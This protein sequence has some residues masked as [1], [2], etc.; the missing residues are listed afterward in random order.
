MAN[1]LPEK[2]LEYLKTFNKNPGEYTKEEQAEIGIF[3]QGLHRWEKNWND[4]AALLGIKDKT[5]EQFRKWVLDR[6]Y[7]RNLVP[8]NPK[9]LDDKTVDDVIEEDVAGSL[10]EQRQVL[11]KE[12]MK[13]RDERTNLNRTL[14]DEARLERFMDTLKDIAAQD[15]LNLPQLVNTTFDTEVPSCEAVYGLA[16]L[17]LGPIVD[18]CINTYNY[19]EAINR[20]NKIAEDIL[21]YCQLHNVHTLHFINMGDLIAGLIHPTIRLE[22]EYDVIE[23]VKIAAKLVAELVNC[24]R[25]AAPVVTYRSVVDNHARLMPDKHQHIEL[26][27][28]NR[29]IDTLVE[30]Y[31]SN[32]NV[33]FPKDNID[34]GIG[35]II[36]QDG[37]KLYFMHGHEDKKTSVVQDIMGLTHEFPDYI[38]MAHFHNS[39]VHTF[40]GA[41]LFI[42]GSV[43][44]TDSY[45]FS[46]R[47]FNQPEQKLLIFD[48]RN[49]VIDFDLRC[50]LDGHT[51]LED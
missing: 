34:I 17:H 1:K 49:N 51:V 3:H 20:V 50:T 36:L 2:F 25:Q 16:D 11:V 47:L 30:A 42:S 29:I 18:N 13:L 5:G 24:L 45:A 43:I 10:E 39:A 48:S 22:Q 9:V 33:Q 44:G 32:T 15:V 27:N 37:K 40:Q 46:K 4:V 6:R 28:L 21:Y 8:K 41:K 7:A 38:L 14:R 19:T 31:L 23:Q 26:E 35:R 12:R